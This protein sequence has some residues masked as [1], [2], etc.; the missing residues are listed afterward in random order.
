MAEPDQQRS[1]LVVDDNADLRESLEALLTMY[2][3]SVYTAENG[4]QALS[5]MRV[6]MPDLVISDLNMPEMSGFEFLSIVRCRFPQ[7][8]SIASSGEYSGDQVP[9]G[10]IA[11]AFFAKGERFEKLMNI[12]SRM[13][14]TTPLRAGDHLQ[15]KSATGSRMPEP[16]HM[17]LTNP[18]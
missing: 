1:I 6:T 15:E 7:V 18:A 9:P 11:D 8:I 14:R 17:E 13:M 5:Q 4:L 10:V 16:G 12:I 2:G 3:Y